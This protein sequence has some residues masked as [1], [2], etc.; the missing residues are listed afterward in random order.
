[1]S[2][3]GFV[4]I[5]PSPIRNCKHT[6]PEYEVTLKTKPCHVYIRRLSV[7]GHSILNANQSSLSLH[8]TISVVSSPQ[9]N[10]G[11]RG[12]QMSLSSAVVD[13]DV[14]QVF[15]QIGAYKGNIV[16]IKRIRK[17]HVD[18]TRNVRKELKIVRR[19]HLMV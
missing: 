7:G 4:I 5:P 15:T 16:A 9:V 3:K 11:L 10:S 2:Y 17:K 6:A 13:V 8:T 12:S 19:K 1:M 18:L 14:K